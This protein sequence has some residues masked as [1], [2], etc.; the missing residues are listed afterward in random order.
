LIPEYEKV[1]AKLK[2]KVNVAKLLQSKIHGDIQRAYGVTSVPT[3]KLIRDGLVFNLTYTGQQAEELIDFVENGWKQ[4][5]GSAVP[6]LT[7]LAPNTVPTQQSISTP[8]F[9]T[10][11]QSSIFGRLQSLSLNEIVAQFSTDE[12]IIGLGMSLLLLS[13]GFCL[14]RLTASGPA[15]KREDSMKKSKKN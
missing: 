1:A 6:K 5:Q 8:V 14:G 4:I 7:I 13:I 3:L 10:P 12:A 15:T 11:T 2:G 9:P